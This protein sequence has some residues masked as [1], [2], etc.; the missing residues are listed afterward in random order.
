MKK[1]LI[2]GLSAIAL[3]AGGAVYAQNHGGAMMGDAD[4]NGVITRAEAQAGAAAMFARM[5][6]NKD[7]ALTEAD[8]EARMAERKAEMFAMM[9]TD[10]NGQISRE[11]FMAHRHEGMRG[12]KDGMRG[13]KDGMGHK[14]GMRGRG[15]GMMMQ[16]A[17]TNKDGRISKAEFT[18]AA[19]ARFDATDANKDG[20]VTSDERKAHREEMRGKWRDMKQGG[21]AS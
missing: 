15:G 20:Q 8:R 14:M 19:M 13:D 1:S 16:M 4:G 7:G 11:E 18:A 3:A 12:D 6:A 9:D 2:I 5:D 10:K 17:D 21:D